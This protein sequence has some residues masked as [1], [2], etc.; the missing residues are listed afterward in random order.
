MFQSINSVH[1]CHKLQT[2]LESLYKLS[3][4]WRLEFNINKCKILT[5]SRKKSFINYHYSI[6]GHVLEKVN[7]TKDLGLLLDTKLK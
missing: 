5:V 7:N 6:N 3:I 4:K 2:D 1:D